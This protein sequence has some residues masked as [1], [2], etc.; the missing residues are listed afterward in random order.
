MIPRQRREEKRE[1]IS[2]WK[3]ELHPLKKQRP[4]PGIPRHDEH[5]VR[6][7]PCTSCSALRA[8][9]VR[10]LRPLPSTAN[11]AQLQRPAKQSRAPGRRSHWP[12]L[13]R[14]A[15][16]GARGARGGARPRCESRRPSREFGAGRAAWPG[17]AVSP[18]LAVG[19][20]GSSVPVRLSDGGGGARAAARVRRRGG[21][22]VPVL[23]A[24]G[25]G[26]AGFGVIL[27][28]GPRSLWRLSGSG[29][30]L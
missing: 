10:N 28:P 22:E 26:G 16:I 6:L 18:A 14:R 29:R 12:G 7:A 13:P 25:R 27:A 8:L 23:R 5:T 15:V 9:L 17:G 3:Q 19:A 1:K 11:T 4:T 24:A 2:L 30:P 21:E 20:S